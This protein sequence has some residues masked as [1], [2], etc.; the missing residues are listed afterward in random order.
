MLYAVEL[1][2][3]VFLLWNYRCML[4]AGELSCLLDLKSCRQLVVLY[5]V[6]LE[7]SRQLVLLYAVELQLSS[8]VVRIHCAYGWVSMPL[9]VPHVRQAGIRLE[10]ILV[11][12]GAQQ[13]SLV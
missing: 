13:V 11:M 10:C 6:E 1:E 2:L 8:S 9:Q 4:Y 5:A 12:F 3:S 7:S